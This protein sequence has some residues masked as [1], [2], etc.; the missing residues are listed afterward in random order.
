M[1]KLITLLCTG[2]ALQLHAQQDIHFSQYYSSPL[3]LNPATAGMFRGDMR[4]NLNYRNQWA[5]VTR[6]FNTIVA[7][8]DAPVYS[9]KKSDNFLALGARFFHD[10]A[11]DSRFGSTNFGLD[12]SY[13]ISTGKNSFFGVGLGFGVLSRSITPSGLTWD[14]QW[15]GNAFDNS[16]YSGE[17]IQSESFATFDLNGGLCYMF[18]DGDV[19]Y[20][21]G[22]GIQHFNRPNI[23]FLGSNEKLMIKYVFHGQAE[24]PLGRT[25]TALVPS[26]VYF[27]QG[28]NMELTFGSDYKIII[29]QASQ[30]LTFND[31][32]S[33]SAGLYTRFLDALFATFRF[34]YA[35][36]SVGGAYDFTMSKLSPHT[37]GLG[38]FELFAQYIITF[39]SGG[40]SSFR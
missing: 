8:I 1:K 38:G 22:A 12:A 7:G 23:S 30:R 5:T 4:T 15:N 3:F 6:P 25:N 26:A 40:V 13:A 14:Q 32:I 33:L 27:F 18:D 28:P 37:K 31:E 19:R 24:F 17:S 35:G 16:L 9:P 21:L 29:K 39:G 36:L 34:N 11:G 10:K 2:V 20:T